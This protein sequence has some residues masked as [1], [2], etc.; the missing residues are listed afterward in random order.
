MSDIYRRPLRFEALEDRRLLAIVTVTTTVDENNGTGAVSL[1]EAVATAQ[2]GDTIRFSVTGTINLLANVSVGH[3]VINK[4]LTIEGPGASQLTISA[5]D[6]DG[7]KNGNGRRAFVVD[8]G[9]SN[10]ATVTISGLTFTNGDP[11]VS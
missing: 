4:N 3:I 9:S 10:L 11:F 2:P 6:T 8:D 7:I 5:A 1:R